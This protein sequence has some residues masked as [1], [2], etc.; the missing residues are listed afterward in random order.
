MCLTVTETTG[1]YLTN[2]ML[3]E[4]EK[5]GLDIYNYPGQGCDNV[6]NMATRKPRKM[7][8]VHIK[9]RSR[10]ITV[11]GVEKW[12]SYESKKKERKKFY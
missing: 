3:G 10:A 1:E 6:A 11:C 5:N 12:T 7:Y 2:V 9:F 8:L 4:L